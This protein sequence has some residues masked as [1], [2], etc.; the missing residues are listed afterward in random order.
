MI[1][2]WTEVVVV[3]DYDKYDLGYNFGDSDNRNC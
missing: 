1:L 2:A 3:K